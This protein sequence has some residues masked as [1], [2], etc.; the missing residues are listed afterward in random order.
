[1]RQKSNG[2]ILA[3][4]GMQVCA[5]DPVHHTHMG[6]LAVQNGLD[7]HPGCQRTWKGWDGSKA[8]SPDQVS[9]G[10]RHVTHTFIAAE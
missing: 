8:G 1:M 6:M 5:T 3:Q 2:S 7:D 4:S 9:L 10:I